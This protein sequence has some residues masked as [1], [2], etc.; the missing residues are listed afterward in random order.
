[1][2]DRLLFCLACP[3]PWPPGT[4]VHL[5][6]LLLPLWKGPSSYPQLPPWQEVAENS[7]E[8][9]LASGSILELL[10]LDPG[11]LSRWGPLP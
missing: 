8:L 5:I 4:A 7:W 9:L 1:M 11:P 10:P 6:L 3:L 2:T